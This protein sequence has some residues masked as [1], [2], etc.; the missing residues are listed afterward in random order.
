MLISREK[1]W[2]VECSRRLIYAESSQ[3]FKGKKAQ[4]YF[5]GKFDFLSLN[6]LYP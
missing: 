5:A 4:Q 2:R 6:I 3:Q 1:T